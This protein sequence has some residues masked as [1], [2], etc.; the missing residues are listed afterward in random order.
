MMSEEKLPTY[1]ESYY[2]R[3][4]EESETESSGVTEEYTLM[5][6]NPSTA[7]TT[8]SSSLLEEKS[9]P[10]TLADHSFSADASVTHTTVE[11]TAQDESTKDKEIMSC[12]VCFQL[13]LD[14]V[15]LNCGHSFCLI[16]LA[17]LWHS[18]H[19]T[20]LLCPMCRQPW[21]ESGG[22]LPSVN[23]IFRYGSSDVMYNYNLL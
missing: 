22:R 6:S 3:P 2:P 18:A 5:S 14:P 15:T 8:S 12:G 16:C 21:A 4:A 20:V 17:Q 19:N 1:D 10:T 23:V 13:L 9:E 11:G 7:T